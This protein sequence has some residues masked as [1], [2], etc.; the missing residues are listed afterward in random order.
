MSASWMRI[1]K[2]YLFDLESGLEVTAEGNPNR[3]VGYNRYFF[4]SA[5]RYSSV[6]WA[7]LTKEEVA[8]I[9][10]QINMVNKTAAVINSLTDNLD[11]Q[12]RCVWRFKENSIYLTTFV[13]NWP[14]GTGSDATYAN[15]WYFYWP[16]KIAL[17][18][19]SLWLAIPIID[20]MGYWLRASECSL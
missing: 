11:S 15:Q 16:E 20:S 7:V 13:H 12:H 14:D 6:H 4:A 1:S 3:S 8:Q 18:M 10:I 2:N 19:H 9:L 5:H 17:S